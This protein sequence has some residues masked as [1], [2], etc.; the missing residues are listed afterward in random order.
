MVDVVVCP[1]FDLFC[2]LD[3]FLRHVAGSLFAPSSP[4]LLFT[5]CSLHIW[6]PVSFMYITARLPPPS[7]PPPPSWN[8]TPLRSSSFCGLQSWCWCWCWWCA[9][10]HHPLPFPYLCSFAWGRSAVP[11]AGTAERHCPPPSPSAR[12]CACPS[13]VT[14]LLFVLLLV[15]PSSEVLRP[16]CKRE[17]GSTNNV[18]VRRRGE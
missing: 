5:W 14:C 13:L 8:G 11:I 3:R 15:P 9:S 1:F 12:V 2:F 4:P 6:L 18:M 16:E 7:F 17:G 10:H